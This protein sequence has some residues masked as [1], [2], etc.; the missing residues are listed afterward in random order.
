MANESVF[1]ADEIELLARLGIP[2]SFSD[3]TDDDWCALEEKVGDHLLLKCLDENYCPNS[4]GL[5]CEDIL[6]KPSDIE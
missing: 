1:S 6:A 3:Y 2:T 5:I 4:D